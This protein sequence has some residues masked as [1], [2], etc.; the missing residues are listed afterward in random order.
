M[1]TE[2]NKSLRTALSLMLCA[3]L[4]L[5]AF[6]VSAFAV[7]QAEIDEAEARRDALTEQRKAAQAVVDGLEEEQASVLERK[8]AMDER[9]Q[10]TLE[11]MELN[12]QEIDLYDQLIAEKEEEVKE[13]RRLE[14]EQLARYRARVRAMEENGNYNILSIIFQANNLG[15]LLTTMDDVGEIMESDRQLEDAYIAAREN[16]ESVKADYEDTRAEL[17]ELKAQLKAEQEELEKDIEE[18]I[19]IILDLENDRQSATAALIFL[20]FI[21]LSLSVLQAQQL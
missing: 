18:A 14:E 15:E 7:T 10:F 16:T 1:F 5:C 19:Q 2:R 12:A 8:K 3:V 17:E 6:P 20:L 11:Q 13:A 9:N 21:S 4:V